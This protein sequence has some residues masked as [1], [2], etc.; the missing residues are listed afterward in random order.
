MTHQPR[1]DTRDQ[2]DRFVHRHQLDYSIGQLRLVGLLLLTVALGS[3]LLAAGFGSFEPPMARL[4]GLVGLSPLLPLLPLGFCLYFLGGGNRRHR[5]E[6]GWPPALHR[7][8]LPLA[9]LCL[10]ALPALTLHDAYSLHSQRPRQQLEILS[11]VPLLTTLLVQGVT[12]AG[13]LLM[14]RQG[15]RQMQRVGLTPGLFFRTDATGPVRHHRRRSTDVGRP[16][17][18]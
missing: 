10:L 11:S 15:R 3:L 18:D 17:A 12:G 4:K 14:R 2:V 5:R 8:L 1:Q 16:E 13:L 6:Q 9:L 7:A